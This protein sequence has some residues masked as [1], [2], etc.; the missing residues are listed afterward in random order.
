V[1]AF[2]L[3]QT[4]VRRLPLQSAQSPEKAASTRTATP[5]RRGRVVLRALRFAVALLLE[6]PSMGGIRRN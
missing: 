4:A 1:T 3:E 2:P 5:Q 6:R